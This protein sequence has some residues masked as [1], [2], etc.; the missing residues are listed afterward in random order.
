MNITLNLSDAHALA[1]AWISAPVT[2]AV[3]ALFLRSASELRPVVRGRAVVATP[4]ELRGASAV[5]RPE[6]RGT[7]CVVMSVGPFGSSSSGEVVRSGAPT[8]GRV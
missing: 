4:V 5:P 6:P 3:I 2:A 7:T 1:S 8:G